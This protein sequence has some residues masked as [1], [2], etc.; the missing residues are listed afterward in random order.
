MDDYSRSSFG[1]I[2]SAL[3]VANKLGIIS[4]D[5]DPLFFVRLILVPGS[6]ANDRRESGYW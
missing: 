1:R 3:F 2:G 6:T 4:I 5:V